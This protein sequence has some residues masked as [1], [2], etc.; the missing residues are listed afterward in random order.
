MRTGLAEAWRARVQDAAEENA[1]WQSTAFILS[2]SLC[3]DRQYSEA[4]RMFREMHGIWMRLLGAE[5]PQTLSCAGEI[6]NYLF[7]QGKYAT[8]EQINREALA[9]KGA[10]WDRS[11]RTRS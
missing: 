9:E 3:S 4:E 11:I 5:H 6:A 7:G 10:C 2:Q 8:A 1:K